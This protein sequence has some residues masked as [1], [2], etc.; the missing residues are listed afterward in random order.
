MLEW[1][2]VER[3]VKEQQPP[4]LVLE[5]GS[6]TERLR[7]LAAP[8]PLSV[9]VLREGAFEASAIEREYLRLDGV[10]PTR[11][12]EVILGLQCQPWV[13]ART[14]MPAAALTGEMRS[15]VRLG[16]RPL[17]EWLFA[18]NDVQRG[19]VDVV[20][21]EN[22]ATDAAYAGLMEFAPATEPLWGRRSL[23]YVGAK[24]L[25]VSEYF[26]PRLW[27]RVRGRRETGYE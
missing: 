11:I 4:A 23:F 20:R 27:Q 8:Q 7:R 19:R 15:L 25:L 9:R 18:R 21:L 16:A 13:L 24:H 17:G 6:L 3:C 2:D 26:L 1:S 14:V 22:A 5:R 12:R 10:A